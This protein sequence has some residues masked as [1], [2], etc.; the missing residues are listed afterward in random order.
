VTV[1]RTVQ[2]AFIA[3]A[4]RAARATAKEYGVPGAVTLAQAALESD[5][6]RAHMGEANNYFGIKAYDKGGVP[7]IGPIAKGFVTLPTREVVNGRSITVNARFRSYA[8]M[9]DSFRDHANFLKVNSR[10]APAFAHSDDPDAFARAIAKA[11]YATDPAYA[12]KLIALMRQ[13]KLY[14]YGKRTAKR[15]EDE[16]EAREPERKARTRRR[17]QVAA[18]QGSLNEHLRRLG[19][20]RLLDVDGRWG[21]LT[22]IAFADVCRVLGIAAER[23]ARTYRIVAGTSV[24]RTP[25][26]LARAEGDGVAFADELRRR[27]A[28]ERAGATVRLGG[29]PLGDAE[30][31]R[32]RIAA[33]QADLN[34]H[35]ER[36]RQPTR[37]AVD[38]EW[39]QY[40]ERAFEA[41]CR[42]LGIEAERDPRTFRIIAGALAGRTPA[43]RER[44]DE[45]GAAYARRLRAA[46][47]PQRAVLGGRPL[48]E[49]ERRAAA[50]VC[51]QRDL[52]QHLIRLGSPAVLALDGRWG[53][54]TATAFREVCRTLGLAAER[55]V[56]TYRLVG[57]AL[58]APTDAERDRAAHEGAA[59]AEE[60]RKRFARTPPPAGDTGPPEREPDREERQRRPPKAERIRALQAE[61]NRRFEAW[62]VRKRITVDGKVGPETRKAA[63]E[64]AKGR[65][66]HEFRATLRKRY[67]TPD[68]GALLRGN[69][70][71]RE[72]RLLEV[73]VAAHRHGLIVTSTTGGSHAPGSFHY[74]G[75]AVD[76]GVAGNPYGADAQRRFV[77]FQHQLARHPAGLAELIG[78]DIARNV[79]YGRFVRYPAA[80]EQAHKNHVHCAI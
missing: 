78:P 41:V 35:L 10:Y 52:N 75:R 34:G 62:R 38:G 72:R 8:S 46:G 58:A 13:Y 63:H 64:V 80:T 51:L 37:L 6:G 39:D 26:E 69:A 76:F 23:H 14:G 42:V 54:H 59:F 48:P 27:F 40:T 16:H 49:D 61:C 74:Q 18:L 30:Q 19:A 5:W 47:V 70:A 73:I 29:T 65:K 32:A 3:R 12:D 20:P 68:V 71:P 31:R 67:A 57:A 15:D 77:A 22:E 4:A 50:V 53:D 25:A 36:L 28:R 7:Q 21:P 79:K 44:A 9:A 33:L 56:R 11:G 45:D 43:E 17:G 60:L 1:T 2:E 66:D 55:D 24:T